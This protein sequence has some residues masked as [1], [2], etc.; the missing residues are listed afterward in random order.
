MYCEYRYRIEY[1]QIYIEVYRIQYRMKCMQLTNQRHTVISSPTAHCTAITQMSMV[2]K[3]R[4]LVP[5]ANEI[6]VRL[7]RSNTIIMPWVI[8]VC[9]VQTGQETLKQLM[10]YSRYV[11]FSSRYTQ[12][13]RDCMSKS[14][15][16]VYTELW[17]CTCAHKSD[18]LHT[19]LRQ[20]V[21]ALADSCMHIR[22]YVCTVVPFTVH[23]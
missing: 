15:W 12:W 18:L 4:S 20:I 14:L 1:R 16:H 2:L 19:R 8:K 9:N 11:K 10:R 23:I 22:R 3:Q 5:L 7:H 21:L 6:L 13:I 17:M